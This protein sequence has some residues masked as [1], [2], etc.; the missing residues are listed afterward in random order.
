MQTKE[1]A[2]EGES[3]LLPQSLSLHTAKASPHGRKI[4]IAVIFIPFADST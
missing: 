3:N 2:R 1:G 4:E